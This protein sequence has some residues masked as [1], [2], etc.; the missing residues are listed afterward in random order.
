MSVLARLVIWL[1]VLAGL[2]GLGLFLGDRIKKDSG[3]VLLAYDVY[4]IEMSLWTACVVV[5]FSGLF[6]WVIF[7]FSGF[8]GNIPLRLN[9]AWRSLGSK[10]A[11]TRLVQ[12]ALWLRRD[13][14][15]R[16]LSVLQQDTKQESFPAL[17]W[18]LA[19]EAARRLDRPEQSTTYLEIA[20]SLMNKVPSQVPPSPM[21][22]QTFKALLKYLKKNWREDWVYHLEFVGNEDALTR[23]SE[24]NDL[25][26][27]ES[28]ALE[29]VLARLALVS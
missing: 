6:L 15:E 12:G 13:N 26:N 19:S 14:P 17:H 7:G 24:L 10:R 4:T 25:S 28:L 2:L 27:Y 9:S 23:L 16:A 1:V 3:Y 20:E 11:N 29:V 8:L 22:P 21:M 5:I 18:L